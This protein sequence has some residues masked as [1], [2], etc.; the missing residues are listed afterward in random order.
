[1]VMAAAALTGRRSGMEA[2]RE[3]SERGEVKSLRK[4]LNIRSAVAAAERNPTIAEVAQQ[5]GIARPTAYRLV[6]TLV[7]EGFLVQEPHDNRLYVG[8]ETLPLA[9]SLLDRNRMR[10]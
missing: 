10:L 6:Q 9:A 3:Q 2:G 1:M 8:F 7:A 4:A 5:V